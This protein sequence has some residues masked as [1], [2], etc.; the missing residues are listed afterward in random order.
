MEGGAGAEVMKGEGRRGREGRRTAKEG[1]QSRAWW[2]EG[3]EDGA[4]RRAMEGI[5]KDGR[6][7]EQGNKRG[8]EGSYR[9]RG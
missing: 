7:G 5:V 8:R 9:G 2:G 4:N 6:R 3:R 1:D